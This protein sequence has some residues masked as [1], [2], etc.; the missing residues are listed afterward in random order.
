MNGLLTM[1]DAGLFC[2]AGGFH[3]DPWRPVDRALITHAH[4]DHARGGSRAYL[5]TA[6]G[7]PLLRARLPAEST[8]ETLGYGEVRRIGDVEV[9]FHPAGHVLGSAQVRV[10]RGG[11]VVVV[12]GDYKLAPDPSCTPFEPVRCDTFITESTFGLPIYRW[13]PPESLMREIRDWWSA[14]HAD[15][16]TSVVFAYALGKAQRIAAGVAALGDLPGPVAC[17]GAVARIN[18]AYREAGVDLPPMQRVADAGLDVD[19][20]GALILAPPSAQARPLRAVP[21]GRC[22]GLDGDTGDAT[23]REPRP[24]VRALRPRRL[25]R[26]QRGGGAK[27]RR[28]SRRDARLSRRV[29]ALACGDTP[30]RARERAGHALRGG[31]GRRRTRGRR[32]RERGVAPVRP[33]G[34]SGPTAG[35]EGR[36]G[37]V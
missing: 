20:R 19:W 30:R 8:I 33:G 12:S 7:L 23:A 36:P 35:R 6:A 4:A 14:N 24:R 37:R 5:A 15:G 17:H 26:T 34:R 21:H 22:L 1:T 13:K 32:C 11:R 2:P 9:S 16:F 25:A 31:T 3:I 18:D 27:R 10:A 29:R 28:R